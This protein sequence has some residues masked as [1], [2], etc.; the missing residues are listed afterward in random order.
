LTYNK[1]LCDRDISSARQ[2]KYAVDALSGV[3]I[4]HK[5]FRASMEK[6]AQRLNGQCHL[7]LPA[8]CKNK[9]ITPFAH[10]P[11]ICATIIEGI[12]SKKSKGY[13]HPTPRPGDGQK[14]LPHDAKPGGVL[15]QSL[16][17]GL[18]H[19]SPQLLD[20]VALAGLLQRSAETSHVVVYS[21]ELPISVG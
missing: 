3:V 10:F 11:A 5:V 16:G 9:L 4:Y 8:T 6:H 17:I 15:Y 14:D 21:V 20:E 19:D 7:L 13:P 2:W 12:R 1:T 18:V